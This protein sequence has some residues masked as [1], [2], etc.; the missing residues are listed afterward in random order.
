MLE[1]VVKVWGKEK[2]HNGG[3]G[4]RMGQGSTAWLLKGWKAHWKFVV[5]KSDTSQGGCD[6]F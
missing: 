5:M 3:L 1:Q 6:L 2:I 4:Q